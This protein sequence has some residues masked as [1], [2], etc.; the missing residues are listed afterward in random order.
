MRPT[1]SYSKVLI[2]AGLAFGFLG[3]V[4]QSVFHFELWQSDATNVTPATETQ[5]AIRNEVLPNRT[6]NSAEQRQ[7]V[8]PATVT[9]RP[10]P[11]VAAEDTLSPQDQQKFKVFFEIWDSRT[12]NDPRLDTDLRV[13]S[14]E[15]K[16]ALK[17]FYTSLPKEDFAGRGLVSMLIARQAKTVDDLKFVNKVL[18]EKPCLSL[19]N[20]NEA[21]TDSDPHHD[22]PNGTTLCYPQLAAV[23]QLQRA[24]NR[25]PQIFQNSALKEQIR[26]A[27]DAGQKSSCTKV[28]TLA[29]S[30][31][32]N[33][34]L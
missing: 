3:F 28:R 22:D 18:E 7:T 19:A 29:T 16:S 24:V 6:I 30:L 25:D 33:T 5:A 34:H 27:I 4:L 1:P 14:K 8:A 2:T 13:L 23:Y 17:E 15:L 12:D 20:C 21:S 26:T 10:T 31:A 32:E 11:T 9:Q